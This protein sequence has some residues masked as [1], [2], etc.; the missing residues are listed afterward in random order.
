M[1]EV[2]GIGE[3]HWHHGAHNGRARKH[4]RSPVSKAEGEES[5]DELV[6]LLCHGKKR[7]VGRIFYIQ[8]QTFAQSIPQISAG[9]GSY[10]AGRARVSHAQR[11]H[12]PA[13]T[14]TVASRGGRKCF[15]GAED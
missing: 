2:R 9:R 8:A 12:H 4:V 7:D 6:L 14:L 3:H 10:T 13:V 5:R 11:K 1:I 15:A